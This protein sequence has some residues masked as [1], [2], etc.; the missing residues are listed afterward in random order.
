M[1]F[2]EF[3]I[4]P[5]YIETYSADQNTL[6]PLAGAS[7]DDPLYARVMGLVSEG[8]D[9]SDSSPEIPFNV[10]TTLVKV[11]QEL[12]AGKDVDALF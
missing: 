1:K 10:V 9:F 3:M 12:R 2:L 8:K 4:Q 11:V 6:S 7:W 5:Q